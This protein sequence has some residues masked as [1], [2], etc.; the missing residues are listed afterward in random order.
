V[1]TGSASGIG[2]ATDELLRARGWRTIGIDLREA[3]VSCDLSNAEQRRKAIARVQGLCP[4]GLDAIIACAGISSRNEPK[5]VSVNFF[6]VTSLLHGLKEL[7]SRSTQPR[8]VVI[9][10]FAAVLPT[11]PAIV[12]ACLAEDETAAL[13]A[14]A[15]AITS[16]PGSPVVYASSKLAVARWI[17]QT[18]VSPDWAG[19][20]ILL[21]AIAPGTIETPM[22]AP[23]LAD[24]AKLAAHR[25]L[26]PCPLGR[27]GQA[28][29]IARAIAFFVSAENS[30][31]TGQTLFVDG[32]S[33]AVLRPQAP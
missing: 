4:D 23:I 28:I 16:N 5:V 15:A 27:V 20:G 21:N 30:F 14:S 10:S 3:A 7:L 29:E 22:M 13:Q 18:A 31:I 33:E 9:S 6:G 8:A 24:A 32:G 26:V 25:Q 2:R 17:R 1:I 19:R 12:A 11:D